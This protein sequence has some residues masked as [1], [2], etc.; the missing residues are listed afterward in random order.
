MSKINFIKVILFST[1]IFVSVFCAILPQLCWTHRSETATPKKSEQTGSFIISHSS[2]P[3]WPEKDG[4]GNG[5]HS[6]P[7]PFYSLGVFSK[8]LDKR[9]TDI[10]EDTN[11]QRNGR[12]DRFCFLLYPDSFLFRFYPYAANLSRLDRIIVRFF[13]RLHVYLCDAML[14]N[15][16][17][18]R[19][20]VI[21]FTFRN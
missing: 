18:E 7:L 15:A 5:S 8:R 21:R 4:I 9:L 19:G 2:P 1:H 11:N 10:E 20:L 13:T 12:M 6:P 14:K 17:C 3:R 16:F